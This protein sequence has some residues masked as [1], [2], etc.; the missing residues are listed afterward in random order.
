LQ[1]VERGLEAV[2]AA[3]QE[4]LTI[5]SRL[6]LAGRGFPVFSGRAI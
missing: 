3:S 2:N 1:P 6:S 5:F 4:I